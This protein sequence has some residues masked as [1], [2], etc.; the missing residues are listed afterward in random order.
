MYPHLLLFHSHCCVYLGPRTLTSY[1]SQSVWTLLP[2][3]CD[4]CQVLLAI[5][6]FDPA[7]FTFSEASEANYKLYNRLAGN[8]FTSSV[9]GACILGLVLGILLKDGSGQWFGC[10]ICGDNMAGCPYL[11]LAKSFAHM[12]MRIRSSMLATS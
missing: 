10:I 6:G 12:C 9:A 1:L 4:L 8:S 5:Q 7:E 3:Y 2:V 11:N